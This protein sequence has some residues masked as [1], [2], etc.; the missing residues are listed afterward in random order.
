[1]S[2]YENITRDHV[3]VKIVII[4]AIL[5]SAAV[6]G[7]VL[8]R[9]SVPDLAIDL[10][11]LEEDEQAPG[12]LRIARDHVFV[13]PTA[14]P[15]FFY[16]GGSMQEEWGLVEEEIMMAAEAGVHQ[17][18]VPVSA[19]WSPG[20]LRPI[21]ERLGQVILADPLAAILVKVDL[22]PPAA[23]LAQHAMAQVT[24]GGEKQPYASPAS[25]TWIAAAQE[26]LDRL[27]AAAQ[28]HP[29]FARRIIGVIP[30]A[31]HQGQWQFSGGYDTSFAN[32]QGFRAWLERVYQ[33]ED[34][35]RAAW[36][37]P[38]ASFAR[39]GI[40]QPP[41]STDT[42]EVFFRLP[43]D[44]ARIDFLH[45]TSESVADAIAALTAHVKA[46]A[47]HPWQV[48]VPYGY[49][50]ELL[51]NDTGH[52]ALGLLTG[53]D[54]DGFISSVSYTD[55]GI[56]GSGGFMGPVS[57]A[58]YH[59]KRWYVVDDT[60]TGVARD[61]VTG[62]VSRLK[63]IRPE[64][65]YNVQERNFAAAAVHRLGI[66]WADP[67][68]E[69]WLHDREQ[70]AEFRKLKNI[71]A[72]LY[73]EGVPRGVVT[74]APLVLRE[75]EYTAA[76]EDGEHAGEEVA[77]R[78]AAQG[79]AAED[80]AAGDNGDLEE[81]EDPEPWD[82]EVTFPMPVRHDVALKVVVDE[83][84][85]FYQRSD[86]INELVLLGNR[87]AAMRSGVS[88]QFTLLQDVLEDKSPPASVY[89]F[90][91]AF[92]L[93]EDARE[94]LHARLARERA[95]AIW[96]YAPGYIDTQGA[97]ANVSATTGMRVRGFDA[98]EDVVYVYS[99]TGS[100]IREEE[101]FGSP[102]EV[103]PL[104]Y[105]DDPEADVLATYKA[106]EKPS[107]AMRYMDAGWTSVYVA[108]PSISPGLLREILSI[109]EVP[110]Y[111]RPLRINHF[112]TIHVGDHLLGIHARQI[113]ERAVELDG[114]FNIHDLLD[115]AVGWPQRQTFHMPLKT[116]ETRLLQFTEP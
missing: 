43:G 31:M 97:A 85:R 115:P 6:L 19:P 112:D 15:V 68:G 99:L 92:Y 76:E 7:I 91:N 83:A 45:Y 44:Q 20:E 29:E 21:E 8:A 62:A 98:P 40:P 74:P 4:A 63:G 89:L 109:L 58:H 103:H 65:V 56:G 100:W 75:E 102:L 81:V 42:S 59:E 1:M 55:R 60:R 114:V 82:G 87:D 28:A 39:A 49:S 69:G 73:P 94:A 3:L 113:G 26:A 95:C 32:L 16:A 93:P 12:A 104:F 23:W 2:G 38:D 57:T 24:V 111:M 96:I 41:E 116:G 108:A 13:D 36:D 64:D 10:P 106:S 66:A 101:S 5:I 77:A 9:W 70:W 37:A 17:F 80:A 27:V 51:P 107:V 78:D 84:S 110:N 71:Y 61:A 11:E 88:T 18:I 79:G 47:T 33:D 30:T 52:Y 14:P 25:Q 72:G 34:L 35:L 86:A 53:S 46:Q 105:V 50:L 48:I 67:Q 90:L 22:N 54:I